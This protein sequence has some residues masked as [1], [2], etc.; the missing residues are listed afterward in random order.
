MGVQLLAATDVASFSLT[1]ARL[2]R[3]TN[4]PSMRALLFSRVDGAAL[5]RVAVLGNGRVDGGGLVVADGTQLA[6]ARCDFVGLSLRTPLEFPEQTGL[7]QAP[8]G[9][10]AV[11]VRSGAWGFGLCCPSPIRFETQ[12]S[13]A[14]ASV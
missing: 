11:A 10:V 9:G 2:R 8:T 5:T 13:T 12:L 6:C 1:D 14:L 7:L 4:T 3:T